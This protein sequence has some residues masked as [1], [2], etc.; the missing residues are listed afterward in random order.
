MLIFSIFF[1]FFDDKLNIS[2]NIKFI[3]SLIIII[4]L[5][6]LDTE[7]ILNNIKFSFYEKILY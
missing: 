3:I 6:Y 7:I 4:A 1:R 2:A 5:I